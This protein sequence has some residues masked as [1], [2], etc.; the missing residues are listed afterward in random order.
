MGE[1]RSF[2]VEL[3]KYCLK[4]GKSLTLYLAGTAASPL[5]HTPSARVVS[6]QG[7]DTP[8]NGG[9]GVCF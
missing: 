2:E 3:G 7:A 5:S 4:K 6:W 1:R 9:V 8:G